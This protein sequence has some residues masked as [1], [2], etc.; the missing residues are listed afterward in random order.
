A[1]VY[2]RRS[3]MTCDE[4]RPCQRCVKRNISHLCH[5]ET[6]T[7]VHN[8]KPPK[9]QDSSI[10]NS[11]SSNTAMLAQNLI[12]KDHS[13]TTHAHHRLSVNS[14][15]GLGNNGAD[16]S[17]IAAA[18][19]SNRVTR[20]SS[21]A[22]SL[23]SSSHS[24]SLSSVSDKQATFFMTAA[25]PTTEGTSDERL[26]QVIRAKEEAGLLKPHNFSKGYSRLVRYMDRHM[27]NESR[28]RII[29]V[30]SEFRPKFRS[31]AQSLTETDLIL[32][33]ESF[34][35]MLYDYDRVFTAM[36][37][38]SC[39]WRR[40]GE[41][42]RA[43][44]EF[45]EFVGLPLEYFRDGQIS[46]YE[47]MAEQ[48]DVNYWEKYGNIAFDVSQKAVLTSCVLKKRPNANNSAMDIDDCEATTTCCFSFTIRRDKY[49]IPMIIV[50]NFLPID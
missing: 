40:T 28:A 1:C 44:R 15:H 11:S 13:S 34:E 38:P 49:H 3:H 19:A 37:V 50:G 23:S 26:M 31:I 29:K 33:E 17:Q 35:R 9:A 24:K 27:T 22:S 14:N 20:S 2:C 41:I 18:A 46:I 25:D 45:A 16:P 42:H 10:S 5:D 21:N 48:S 6:R 39:L 47:L 4:G 30:M 8:G 32:V 43:N 7:A 12:N 36:G